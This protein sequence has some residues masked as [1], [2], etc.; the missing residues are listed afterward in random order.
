MSLVYLQMWIWLYITFL[1]C[2]H[3]CNVTF[4]ELRQAL[5]WAFTIM[6]QDGEWVAAAHGLP[7]KWVDTIQG[8]ELWAIL[9]ALHP[10]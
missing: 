8:A 1:S 6:T 5:G 7:P 3:V 4:V 10:A 2:S 9:M